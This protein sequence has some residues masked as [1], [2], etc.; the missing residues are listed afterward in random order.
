MPDYA[1]F[2]RTDQ[3]LSPGSIA[4]RKKLYGISDA[5]VPDVRKIK[6]GVAIY[7]N[8]NSKKQAQNE[9]LEPMNK[10]PNAIENY[11]VFKAK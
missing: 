8:M 9:A 4:R 3:E 1:E 10:D 5:A 11:T 2:K 7:M 6:N